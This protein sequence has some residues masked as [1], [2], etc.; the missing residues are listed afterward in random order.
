MWVGATAIIAAC[1]RGGDEPARSHADACREYAHVV[2]VCHG[3]KRDDDSDI[4]RRQA[5]AEMAILEMTSRSP[6]AQV[7]MASRC[8]QMLAAQ[9]ADPGCAR[10]LGDAR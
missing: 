9:R 3:E 8:E 5:R 1:G 6:E 4:A 7:L 10:A 2:S